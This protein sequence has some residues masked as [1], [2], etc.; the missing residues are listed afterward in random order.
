M[1]MVGLGSAVIAAGITM[2]FLLTRPGPDEVL[3][4][5]DEG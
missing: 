2:W 3:P 4:D 5:L 1:D